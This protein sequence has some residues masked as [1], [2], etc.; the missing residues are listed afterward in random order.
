LV[1]CKNRAS[2]REGTVLV[3]ASVLRRYHTSLRCVLHRGKAA[4][5]ERMRTRAGHV[6]VRT[7]QSE[8]YAGILFQRTL[9]AGQG[10]DRLLDTQVELYPR[11]SSLKAP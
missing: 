8:L 1:D 5:A 10:V 7:C 3:V 9:V 6:W 2:L 11:P 4:T